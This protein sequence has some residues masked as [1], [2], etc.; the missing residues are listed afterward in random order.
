MDRRN[1][2][3]HLGLGQRD[4]MRAGDCRSIASFDEERESGNFETPTLSEIVVMDTT[5]VAPRVMGVWSRC[6]L[7]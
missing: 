6:C 3:P 4:F 5:I 7:V 1:G 2:L